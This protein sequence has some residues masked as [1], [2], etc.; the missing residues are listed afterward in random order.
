M[1]II[2][3][4]CQ[5][6]INIICEVARKFKKEDLYHFIN[7]DEF[8]RMFEEYNIINSL[9][10]IE[11]EKQIWNNLNE[12]KFYNWVKIIY[13]ANKP[14]YYHEYF[15]K[16]LNKQLQ[17]NGSNEEKYN[18]KLMLGFLI[19]LGCDY[20][21]AYDYCKLDFNI[22]FNFTKIIKENPMELNF[23]LLY[24]AYK[25]NNNDYLT[26]ALKMKRI[27]DYNL[28]QNIYINIIAKIAD[29]NNFERIIF[30]LE[31]NVLLEAAAILSENH[32]YITDAYIN[33]YL[34][35]RDELKLVGEQFGYCYLCA[36]AY[37]AV[38]LRNKDVL[39]QLK[40][41]V[42]IGIHDMVIIY[43]M[44]SLP[45]EIF[46][47][48]KT[49]NIIYNYKYATLKNLYSFAFKYEGELTYELLSKYTIKQQNQIRIKEFNG[50][51][52]KETRCQYIEYNINTISE[53]RYYCNDI[54]GFLK[55]YY[56][57]NDSQLQKYFQY[58][59][60]HQSHDEAFNNAS[61]L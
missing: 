29:K 61:Q 39:E 20:S 5:L 12:N 43:Y 46:E 47:Y 37:I 17:F 31:K 26:V 57:L 30:L 6:P 53:Y 25:Q 1:S 52:D 13:Y 38:N 60:Q 7:N 48:M 50:E 34:T 40:Y 19:I 15:K 22:I 14:N 27:M 18:K 9:D 11:T 36:D 42:S 45:K 2:D 8:K 16:E 54:P 51:L 56:E 3:T 24:F 33:K 49:N 10:I 23:K 32:K 4:L 44:K 28:H 35:L 55:A 59:Q 58:R 41:Y 21:E